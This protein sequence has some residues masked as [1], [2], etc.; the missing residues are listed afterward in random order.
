[1]KVTCRSGKFSMGHFGTILA[2]I[3]RAGG[4]Q[5]RGSWELNWSLLCLFCTFKTSQR[6]Q[7]LA[8]HSSCQGFS[9]GSGGV[10]TLYIWII[11]S[12]F[13]MRKKNVSGFCCV[14][15]IYMFAAFR[16]NERD[17]ESLRRRR[18]HIATIQGTM[19]LG[20]ATPGRQRGVIRWNPTNRRAVA[21][22]FRSGRSA[23]EWVRV[24]HSSFQCEWRASSST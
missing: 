6:S 24:C 8:V 3:V 17:A 23:A 18:C 15:C 7:T 2:V 14:V 4:Q 12:F 19:L 5:R 13:R 9:S 10:C 11:S 1:M 16:S 21:D 22:D 20:V